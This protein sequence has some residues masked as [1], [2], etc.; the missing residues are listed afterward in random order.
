MFY[1]VLFLVSWS[2]MFCGLFKLQGSH[3][4]INFVIELP[5]I[6][7]SILTI[8]TIG[9]MFCKITGVEV[10]LASAS[11]FLFL[12]A[13]IVWIIIIYKK[14]RIE[15]IIC[16]FKDLIVVAI[17][18]LLIVG[19]AIHMFSV[20]L[21]LVYLNDDAYSFFNDAMQIIRNKEVGGIYFNGYINALF[22][23]LLSPW[24]P[25]VYAYKVFILSDILIH[26]LEIWMFYALF[27]KVCKKKEMIYVFPIIGILYWLGY[28]TF[29]FMRGNFLYWSTGTLILMYL[30]Y[31]LYMLLE[32]KENIGYHIVLLVL[33]LFANAVC[34]KLYIVV[35]TVIVIGII[36]LEQVR[37]LKISVR[38]KISIVAFFIGI[39]LFIIYIFNKTIGHEITQDVLS[40]VKMVGFTYK[41]I[42]QDFLLFLPL[43]FLAVV[44]IYIKKMRN[45][46]ISNALIITLVICCVM[47]LFTYQNNMSEYYYSKIYYN[48]WALSWLLLSV[49]IDI[50]LEQKKEYLIIIYVVTLG[51]LYN[52]TVIDKDIEM[53]NWIETEY[54]GNDYYNLYAYNL[55]L[56]NQNYRNQELLNQGR[57]IDK[58]RLESCKYILENLN[59]NEMVF[60]CDAGNY[61]EGRWIAAIAK[62]RT[63]VLYVN[64]KSVIKNYVN[65]GYTKAG[66][67]K[68]TSVY[69]EMKDYLQKE[70]I[71]YENKNILVLDLSCLSDS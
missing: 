17:P 63:E 65:A 34:N 59:E 40:Y 50:L 8:Q 68:N 11:V 26:I 55:N 24:V 66:F 71:L 36:A 1:T 31:I 33:G 39:G 21:E 69:V 18:T 29:S 67:D 47:F 32:N 51:C 61:M 60:Y 38:K 16:P 70:N 9:A 42:Y 4:T 41:T 20:R 53:D 3:Q 54:S 22:I 62:Q 35:N 10:S 56:F 64:Y 37:K 44:Y 43:L 7:I 14:V 48:L 5:I 2:W 23:E 19:E 52:G 27:R 15:K 13:I 46:I 6:C 57:Y 45:S 49:V 25:Q 58:S 12:C 30:M 28:P